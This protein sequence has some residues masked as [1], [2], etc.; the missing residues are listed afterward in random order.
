GART[1]LLLGPR[2]REITRDARTAR[3]VQR[4]GRGGGA[5]DAPV[6]GRTRA[7]ALP[8]DTLERDHGLPAAHDHARGARRR[9]RDPRRRALDRRRVLHGLIHHA[10]AGAGIV[11]AATASYGFVAVGEIRSY[12]DA[13]GDGA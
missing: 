8:D 10:A 6:E 2:A 12:V 5:R 3:P 4:H 13:V 7:R 9:H 11:G 1:G